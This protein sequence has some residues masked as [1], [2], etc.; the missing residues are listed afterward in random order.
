MINTKL[1]PIFF[2]IAA[3]RDGGYNVISFS[4]EPEYVF[5]GDLEE[6]LSYLRDKFTEARQQDLP[7]S[8][9]RPER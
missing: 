4:P 6:C 5:A 2:R 9:R 8:Y 7:L 1:E 3:A